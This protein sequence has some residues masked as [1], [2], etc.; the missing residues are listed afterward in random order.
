M[1]WDKSSRQTAQTQIK[2]L[3]MEQFDKD[4]HCLPLHLQSK[5]QGKIYL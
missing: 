3:L 2:L 1:Y 4:L 5:T